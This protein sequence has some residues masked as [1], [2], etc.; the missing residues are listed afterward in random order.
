MSA[1]GGA[2]E[3]LVVESTLSR[4]FAKSP[5]QAKWTYSR[6]CR[7]WMVRADAETRHASH[8]FAVVRI[9]I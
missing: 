3:E 4:A 9:D 6:P 7:T 5:D 8:L 2:W 1:I